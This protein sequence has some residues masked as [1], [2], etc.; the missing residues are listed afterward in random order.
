MLTEALPLRVAVYG[1]MGV[2]KGKLAVCLLHIRAPPLTIAMRAVLTLSLHE[3]HTDGSTVKR[4]L[5]RQIRADP[6]AYAM[7]LHIGDFA[8]DMDERDGRQ[9]DLFMREIEPVAANVPYMVVRGCGCGCLYGPCP[10]NWSMD[11]SIQ[12]IFLTRET[13][14]PPPLATNHTQPKTTTTKDM[15][16]HESAYQFSHYT[17][18]FRNMPISDWSAP[19]RTYNG[20]AP[21]N[22]CVRVAR[23]FPVPD[24]GHGRVLPRSKSLDDQKSSDDS[25][26]SICP[27]CPGG[28]PSTWAPSTS[29]P[30]PPRCTTTPNGTLG[31]STSGSKPTWRRP[32]PTA[33]SPPGSSCTV[34]SRSTARAPAPR[35]ATPGTAGS[36]RGCACL[37]PPPP[38]PRPPATTRGAWSGGSGWRSCFTSTASTFTSA[39]TSTTRSGASWMALA[40]VGVRPCRPHRGINRSLIIINRPR[41]GT[42]TWP[43]GSR[44]RRR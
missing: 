13:T 9:G 43:L 39:A 32:T 4:Q 3:T 31:G 18:R 17:E 24:H 15:G 30:S 23:W 10:L 21:N 40:V 42:T 8:Y 37:P 27:A 20:P 44:P 12:F 41:A 25:S 14:Y 28:I 29:W 11:R 22:W 35:S 26:S 33:P 19:I 16:N 6:D 5:A 34:T 36:A 2:E 38:P 1:D 7:V